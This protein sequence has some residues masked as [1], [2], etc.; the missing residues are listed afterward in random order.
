MAANHVWAY[1]SVYDRCA[2]GEQPKCLSFVD[3]W[4]RERLAIELSGSIRSR[5]VIDVLVGPSA[6][7]HSLLSVFRKWA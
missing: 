1:D 7:T 4:T 2:N 5:Q 3:E 6:P